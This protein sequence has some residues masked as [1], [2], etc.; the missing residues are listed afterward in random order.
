MSS[1]RM[2]KTAIPCTKFYSKY[3]KGRKCSDCSQA[4]ANA[5][6][7]EIWG[8]AEQTFVLKHLGKGLS[9]NSCTHK[10]YH[11]EAKHYYTQNGYIPKWK[12]NRASGECRKIS[13]QSSTSLY[14]KH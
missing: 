4:V 7:F 2:Q 13:M 8:A 10:A 1:K 6:H 3:H 14:N 11:A 5:T 9:S 12:K